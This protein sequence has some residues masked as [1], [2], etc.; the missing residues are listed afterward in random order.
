MT[1]KLARLFILLG[2]LFSQGVLAQCP[3]VNAAF[4][5]SQTNI[6]GPGAQVIS[7]N[8]T[9]T[10]L[11]N[12]TT[13]YEWFLNGASFD[14]TVGLAAPI[15]SNISAVGTYTYMLVATDASVPCTDTAIV[16]VNIY[17]IPT[18]NFNFGPNNACAGVNVGFTNTS[19][20]TQGSTTYLWN[21]GDGATA[22]TLNTSHAYGAGGTYNVTLTVTNG[23]GCTGTFNQNVTA[24]D[25]PVIGISGDDGTGDL[26]NCLLP[27]DPSTSEDVTFFNTTTGAVSYE[28]DFGDGSP[29]FITGSNAPFIHTYTSFGTYTVTMT[30]THANG[31]TVSTTLTV[32]FEKY[33]SAAMTLDITEYSGC[34]PHDLS[35]LTNLSVNANTYVWDFGDGTVITTTSPI[36]PTHFYTTQGSYTISLTAINSCNMANSTIS[37]IIIIDG[38]TA[39]FNTT[40]PFAG[41]TGG[42]APQ[43]MNVTNLSTDAQPVNNYTWNMGNG[44][45]YTN[46]ITPPMQTYDTTGTYTITLIAGNACGPDTITLD[47]TIDTIPVV[48]ILSV[49]LDGCSPLLVQTTNNS[50]D[51]PINYQWFVDGVFVTNAAILP[52]QTFVNTGTN[53]PVNHT[54]QLNGSNQCG[55]DSDSETITVHPETQAIFSVN[56][57]T[58]CVGDDITFTDG[59]FGEALTYEWDF[60]VQTETTAGP[61]TITYNA[62]GNFSVEL[63]VDGFCG[64]DTMLQDVVVLPYPVADFTVDVDTGCVDFDVA[65]TNNS[66]LGGTYNWIFN[67]G[68][69]ATS[70]VYAPSPVNYATAGTYQITLAV[71]LLGCV[72]SDTVVIQANPLPIPSFIAL[73]VDGCTPLDVAFTNTSPNNPGDIFDWNFGNGNTFSGQNPAN[74]M[75]IAASNDSVYSVQLII[76]TADG[77]QD[78]ISTNITV[79]PLPIAAYTPL[80]DT[81]CAGDAIAFLNNSTGASIYQ[82]TFGDGNTSTITSP[83]N[84]YNVTGDIITQLVAVTAF[85]CTDTLQ[86]PIY[87]DSI[88]TTDFLFDIV[89]DI[90]STHF[91]DL[92]IGGPT[93]WQW[94]FGDGSP[95]S[96][97]QNPVHFYGVAGTYNVI[98]TVTNP[99]GC[100]SVINQLVDVSLVPVANFSTSSTCLGSPSSF[101]DLTTG[102]PSFWQWNFGDGSPVDNNQNP[103]HTYGSTGVYNVELI[104]QAGN[105]CADTI[106]FPIT[107]TPVPI[108]DFNFIEVCTNDITVFTDASTGGPDTYFWDFG[109]GTTDNTNNPNP[110]HTYTTSGVY[111]VTLTA[112]YAASGCTNTIVY[113]VNA[114]PRTTPNFSTNTPCLGGVT[115]FTDLTGGAPILWEWDFGDG[116]AIDFNQ[117]PTHV[118]ATPGIFV[119]ELIT[120]NGFGCSDTFLTIVEVF[121]LPNA[122]FSFT[123]VCLNAASGF[124][125]LSTAAVAWEWNFGDGSPLSFN[126]NPIHIYSAAGNFNV[127]L[128]V[129]NMQGCTDTMI[130]SITVNPNPTADFLFST[131]CHTYPSFFTDNSAGALNYFWD[132]GDG[133]PINNSASPS[134]IYVNSGSYNVELIVENVFACTDTITQ[135][136]DVLVQP[137]AG[138]INNT[139]CA[140]ETVVFTDTSTLGPTT[141][142]WDFGDGSAVDNNQNPSHLFNPGGIYTVTLIVGNIAACMDTIVVP[143][144]VYTVPIP[145]FLADTV[146]LFSITTF[147]DMT[148]DSAPLA[149]WDWDFDD[150]NTSFQ[151]NPTYIFQAPGQY[152]V[153]LI[154]TNV[155][156]C[157]S[158]ISIPVFVSDIPV[159]S[160][161]ADT[162]CLGTATNFNDTSIGFP[163]AWTWS[164]GDGTVL[165]SGPNVQHT[166]ANPGSYIASLL[167]TAGGACV[168]QVFQVVEVIDNVQAGII[169]ADSLCDGVPFTFTDNST[170]TTGVID[171]YF[172]DFGDGT[173]S[174]AQNATHTYTGPGTYLV[175]HVVSSLGGCASTAIWT[176]T[177]MDVPV[178]SFIDLAACQNAVTN[179]ADQSVIANGSIVNWTWDFGD[180]SPVNNSQNSNHIFAASGSFMV[181]LTVTSDFGCS[182]AVVI[183]TIVY[184]API[185]DFSAPLSC[186]DD[187]VQYTDLSTIVSGS[188]VS[189]DWN[190]DDGSTD[191]VQNPLHAFQVSNDSF[192]VELIV[193]S[194][195]GCT[196]TAVNLIETYPFPLFQYG[197]EFAAGCEP[198]VVQFNDSSLVAGGIITGWEWDFDDGSASFAEDPIHIFANP[199]SYYVSL[200][201]TTSQGCTFHDALLYPIEVYPKPI[202][203]F[204]P[205][206]VELSIFE[207]EI[208]F[209]D[210]SSGAINW[211]WYFGDG[212]YSNDVNPIHEYTDTG[213][214]QTM[215]IVYSD[216]GCADTAYSTV[217]V[218]GIFTIYVPNTFTPN[219]DAKNQY[220]R[221]YG[222]DI[223][224]YDMWIFNRWGEE[225][226]HATDVNESWDGAYQGVTVQ[227]DVYVW[228]IICYDSNGDE[229]E[230]YGHVTVIK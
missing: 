70:N 90:D 59:S 191:N 32:I 66:T 142:A 155:N 44:N 80:P 214:F 209:I 73:P 38:P 163:N 62:V 6:C 160:F 13:T 206:H 105:G 119:V 140:G 120:E 143:V 91:T 36:P 216:Y 52:D 56:T 211:E 17:P 107:V 103:T 173:T 72:N 227:D 213:Y 10:G 215:Q 122:D 53:F 141:W 123:T 55:N 199:G 77:C 144:D 74:E 50:Y 58:I 1:L 228:K 175:T 190:F 177:V 194:N 4:T 67:G 23:P 203:G 54:I 135:L 48:D 222:L 27:A 81:A 16:V 186:P 202:A 42:C 64:P 3:D 46:V 225:I 229:H 11:N 92:S 118:Y 169:A 37:P 115:N 193:T 181:T 201:I 40:L 33:V 226:W 182:N 79:H 134:Y 188:I 82:W 223:E 147:T 75:Y 22:T 219:G 9:S 113:V 204:S 65:I 161:S 7:F 94:D 151:Q 126:Q 167:V 156:G 30:A 197:P 95:L 131:A 8:N 25:I 153:E 196:D 21:F 207:P 121:P 29:P 170:I 89:C 221:A 130:Q 114:H 208:Q 127:Q 187:T 99:A 78:S 230:L 154:V 176:V 139:V 185:A 220:F 76:T 106:S 108:A 174:S 109:D 164:F 212:A 102:I 104:A 129:S 15:N 111:N 63:I 28:W 69:P 145:D 2:M 124:T 148:T 179:F 93:N 49:P 146:C 195:F 205:A 157:D 112:G 71:N 26:T 87:V 39:N 83:S 5:T 138:F 34:A 20:G 128:V 162:V 198:L 31:C 132:F 110:T 51:P 192:Y 35:T 86:I 60:G 172:W 12:G 117:N 184:P 210:L 166:Y 189:W 136:V 97:A 171:S 100:T 149:S 18:A 200:N 101:T 137:Q 116:S 45:V 88:P 84:V 41:G 178:A 96:N 183:P 152:D 98:L 14:N 224:K 24:M 19:T 43:N 61:H 165:S 68:I 85:G 217:H 180:G 125:D 150:G 158:S 159:A 133:S 47:I 218:Y 168:D 57:D